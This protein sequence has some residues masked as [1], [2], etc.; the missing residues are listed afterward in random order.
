MN[1]TNLKAAYQSRLTRIEKE[2]NNVLPEIL[3]AEWLK[4]FAGA[5]GTHLSSSYL[6][7]IAEP[8][9]DLLARG[10]KR[11][12]PVLLLLAWELRAGLTENPSEVLKLA[13]LAELAHNGS[14]MIDDIEDASELRRGLPAA[15]IL[16]GSDTAINTGNWLY[17]LGTPLISMLNTD[18]ST[19]LKIYQAYNTA[20]L[21]LHFGQGLDI[22]WHRK[23]AYIPDE[24]AY[25]QMCRFKTGSLSA[26]AGCSAVFLRKG[27]EEEAA[28]LAGCFEDLGLAFQ[29]IDDVINLVT[30]NPG[31]MRADD[32]VE[33]KKSL[34]VIYA[35]KDPELYSFLINTFTEIK[36]RD[37]EKQGELCA[38]AA[39]KIIASGAASK[40]LKLAVKLL[41]DVKKSLASEYSENQPL[42]LLLY[43]MDTFSADIRTHAFSGLKA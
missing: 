23:N 43:L 22:Q 19:K 37:K 27:T 5:A 32:I 7:V 38:E 12:R 39:D 14:L 33:G 41:D 15:H 11:W 25:F 2:L 18:E 4:S 6:E 29:I 36:Q 10:G 3:S 16:Y 24:N 8:A 31:K 30:G 21:R 17:F 1:E 42:E 34:P 13:P 28:L 26:F 20:M 40:A 9:R 35:S